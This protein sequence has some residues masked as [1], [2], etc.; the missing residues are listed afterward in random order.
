[1]T[2]ADTSP[3]ARMEPKIRVVWGKG[4]PC[5]EHNKRLV[6]DLDVCKPLV[7][8]LVHS[9]HEKV[10]ERTRGDSTPQSHFI[11]LF[12]TVLFTT[13]YS[14]SYVQRLAGNEALTVTKADVCSSSVTTTQVTD[15]NVRGR[16]HVCMYGQA[17]SII[18]LEE[19]KNPLLL[20]QGSHT[21]IIKVI[22]YV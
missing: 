11:A 4:I 7:G 10:Q 22:A 18:W 16:M 6:G 20:L 21:T 17:T 3:L 8:C 1:L 15:W 13:V 5:Q 12:P 14:T 9:A 19:C 2:K